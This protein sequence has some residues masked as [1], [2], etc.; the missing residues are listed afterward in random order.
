MPFWRRYLE[1]NASAVG[2]A[3]LTFDRQAY[4][5]VGVGK[6]VDRVS[7]GLELARGNV[8]PQLIIADVLG[9]ATS[10]RPQPESAPAR[11]R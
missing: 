2:K 10:L 3:V 8:N 5:V 7:R 4:T 9:H 6:A 11:E 1:G